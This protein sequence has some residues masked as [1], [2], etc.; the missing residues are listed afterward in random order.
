MEIAE[1]LGDEALWAGAAEAYGWHKIVGGE[2]REGFDAQ[3]ARLR[4]GRSGQ[5][6]LLAW[7]A[8][9]IRGQMA[10]GL[11]DPDARPGVL[12]A[13]A[14]AG[15]RGRDRLRPAGGRRHRPLPR[16]AGRAGAA[17]APAR[18][19]QAR[20]DHPLAPAADRPLGRELGSS[21]GARATGARDQPP[22]GQPLGRVGR[23]AP[24]RRAC[25]L[26]GEHEPGGG[27][28]RAAPG[29][30]ART[31]APAT[32]RCGCSPT[33]PAPAPRRGRVEEA[34][35]HVARC[36]EIIDAARTGADGGER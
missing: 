13:P 15:L 8:S 25:F 17:R 1:Q 3:R 31:A 26:R 32:S 20:L 4:G 7:M 22:D 24:G 21:R 6:P 18:R 23:A 30:R 16:V 36:S 9:N 27:G 34:R 19:R 10:W 29:D 12:R 11:G 33:S 5:R 35:A 28:A 2:L 14:R